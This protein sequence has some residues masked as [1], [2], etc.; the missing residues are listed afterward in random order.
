MKR[1]FAN[2]AVIPE[3]LPLRDQWATESFSRRTHCS[4]DSPEIFLLVQGMEDR[5]PCCWLA[6]E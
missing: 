5:G 6:Q 2:G 1:W 3:V 4:C